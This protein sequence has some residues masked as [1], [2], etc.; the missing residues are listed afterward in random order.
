MLWVYVVREVA[1]A[2]G[3]PSLRY[4]GTY[5][6]NRES[7]AGQNRPGSPPNTSPDREAP[8]GYIDHARL[9]VHRIQVFRQ[10]QLL[11]EVASVPPDLGQAKNWSAKRFRP[12]SG[13]ATVESCPARERIRRQPGV[14]RDRGFV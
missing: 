8:S 3:G 2:L 11:E 14:G 9:L 13:G 12:S 6:P 5:A 7:G 10:V 1:L 4:P